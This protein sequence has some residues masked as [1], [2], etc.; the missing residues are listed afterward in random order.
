[1]Y[2]SSLSAAQQ[3]DNNRGPEDSDAW[4]NEDTTRRSYVGRKERRILDI[5]DAREAEQELAADVLK[6]NVTVRKL[7]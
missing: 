4:A 7:T 1:M 6:R 3:G 2:K 5:I